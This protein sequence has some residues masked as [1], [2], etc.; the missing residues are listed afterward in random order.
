M[1]PLSHI[2]AQHFTSSQDGAAGI[3]A[4]PH[5][6]CLFACCRLERQLASFF[7]QL[8]PWLRVSVSLIM[9]P[10]LE[11]GAG[12][13]ALHFPDDCITTWCG[14]RFGDCFFGEVFVTREGKPAVSPAAGV[15]TVIH[16]GALPTRRWSCISSEVL[17][18]N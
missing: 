11:G 13:S 7:P 8:S 2:P 6:P 14:G 9:A 1:L 18:G 16:L 15:I 3:K 17:Q 12:G 10:Q 5:P 4:F